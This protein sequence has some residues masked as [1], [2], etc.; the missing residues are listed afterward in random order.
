MAIWL[1][2]PGTFNEYGQTK[3]EEGKGEGIMAV[4]IP[5]SISNEGIMNLIAETY[6]EEWS[7]MPN[8]YKEPSNATFSKFLKVKGY[9][10]T[11]RFQK[12]NSREMEVKATYQPYQK[13]EDD[14]V[15][16]GYATI[17]QVIDGRDKKIITYFK[18]IEELI[19]T[20]SFRLSFF[21]WTEVIK[22]DTMKYN[23]F[24][25]HEHVENQVK[26]TYIGEVTTDTIK[27]QIW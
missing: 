23:I 12:V 27:E 9:L 14:F 18:H 20:D 3:K 24:G 7:R 22:D 25:N 26:H 1:V 11:E 5:G 16:R 6:P 21:Q 17:R 13:F 10:Y 4:T 2:I 8:R 15:K 19:K